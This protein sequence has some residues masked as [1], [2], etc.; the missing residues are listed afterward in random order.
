MFLQ[1]L[2][3][4]FFCPSS[5]VLSPK[6]SRFLGVFSSRTPLLL[7]HLFS[8]LQPCLVCILGPAF[9]SSYTSHCDSGVMNRGGRDRKGGTVHLD[10]RL[11]WRLS[12]HDVRG[13]LFS[14]ALPFVFPI[15]LP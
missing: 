10:G 14:P 2:V 6:V 1:V 8:V 5:S 7:V 9:S 12:H 3:M 11:V 4:V 13:T 15:W